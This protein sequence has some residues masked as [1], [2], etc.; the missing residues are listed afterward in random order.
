MIIEDRRDA[1]ARETHTVLI[2]AHD[3]YLSG[4]GLA[5]NGKS[6][7][8]WACRPEHASRVFGWVS[9]RHEMSRVRYVQKLPRTGA[10]I[11]VY[12]VEPGHAALGGYQEGG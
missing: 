3:K 7:A 10:H 9:S 5:K 2:A 1:A 6:V 8:V 12:V 4:K 11:S